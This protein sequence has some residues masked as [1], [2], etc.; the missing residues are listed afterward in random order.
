MHS[1]L[2]TSLVLSS[3][4]AGPQALSA[5]KGSLPLIGIFPVGVTNGR[6]D[7]QLLKCKG[8]TVAYHA[9]KASI[10]GCPLNPDHTHF[11]LVDNGKSGFPA[12][13]SEIQFRSE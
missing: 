5:L 7:T 9:E 2:L 10:E 8:Q 4:I 11:I 1:S 12:F 6:K 3:F 13:G